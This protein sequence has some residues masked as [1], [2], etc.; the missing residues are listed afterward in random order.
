MILAKIVTLSM[1]KKNCFF[2][3][4]LLS[5]NGWETVSCVGAQS[6]VKAWR[7]NVFFC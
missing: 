7:E 4:E 5:G 6:G 3:K 2:R 1:L